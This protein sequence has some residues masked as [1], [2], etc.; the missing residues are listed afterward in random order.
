M[1]T[2]LTV[3]CLALGLPAFAQDDDAPKP[4]SQAVA[5]ELGVEGL[6]EKY[7][8]QSE[9]GLDQAAMLYAT[10]KR[11]ETESKLAKV[12]LRLVA[13]LDTWRTL[14]FEARLA[15]I[16]L[17]SSTAGGGSL[18]G[19]AAQREATEVEEFLAKLSARLPLKE[20]EGSPDA[21]AKLDAA[22]ATINSLTP[23]D[24]GDDEAN[25][26]AA[27]QLKESKTRALEHFENIKAMISYI[28]AADS[29]MIANFVKAGMAWLEGEE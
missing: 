29:A 15:P 27:V 24:L 1:I 14:V 16:L 10:A 6:A 9:A 17:A 23:P 4:V 2:R 22:A 13:E 18:Y 12:D 25:K 11:M 20:G 5:L 3:V 28:S 26:E 19:H 8:D 7:T 21:I